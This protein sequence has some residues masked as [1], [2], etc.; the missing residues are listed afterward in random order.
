MHAREIIRVVGVDGPRHD[1]HYVDSK[2]G[3]I[4][5]ADPTVSAS[6]TSTG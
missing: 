5:D 1:L 2:S 3:R 6:A 4:L